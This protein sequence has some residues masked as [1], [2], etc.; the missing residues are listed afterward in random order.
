[1]DL[2]ALREKEK[3]ETPLLADMENIFIEFGISATA[4]HGGN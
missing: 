1:L 4:Y 2:K 3:V